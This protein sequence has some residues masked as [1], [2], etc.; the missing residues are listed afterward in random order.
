MGP[1]I[2]SRGVLGF[3][4]FTLLRSSQKTSRNGPFWALCKFYLFGTANNR[5]ERM[6][7]AQRSIPAGSQAFV[8]SHLDQVAKKGLKNGLFWHLGKFSL[9]GTAKDRSKRVPWAQRSIPAGC[10]AFAFLHFYEVAKKPLEMGL[11]GPFAN[12]IFQG[13]RTIGP[14]ECHGPSDQFLRG[15]RLLYFYTLTKYRRKPLKMGL[16][17]PFANFIF[18]ELLKIGP[19]ECHGPSYQFPRGVRL[20][21]FHTLTKWRK[22]ALKMGFF[23]TWA[24]LNFLELLKIGPNESSEPSVPFPRDLRLL[25]FHSLTKWRKKALK[26]GLFGPLQV[27]TFRNC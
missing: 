8:F 15:L 26:M 23:G 13:L 10:Q 19:N 17:G 5:C 7:W 24:S 1:A 2:N 11:F 4:I 6:P 25:Y 12:F 14:N 9:F 27:L 18:S 20:L 3:C 16:F 22:K 21:Y